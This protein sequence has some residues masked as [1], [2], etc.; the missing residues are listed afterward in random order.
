MLACVIKTLTFFLCLAFPWPAFAQEYSF[1]QYRV[2]HGL[3]SDIIKACA[4]DSLGYFWIATDDGLVKYD[5]IKF[6]TY[7][8]AVHSN[9]TK[10]FF[11]TSK[12][13]LLAFGDLDLIEI[14]NQGDTVVFKSICP[15]YRNPN[16]SSLSYPKLV[17]EDTHGNIWVS[18]SQSVVKLH[19]KSFKR[20]Q[21][22]LTDR[23]PQF[24]RSF[25]IFEDW[26]KNLYIASFQGKVFRFDPTTDRFENY[27]EK[28][29]GQIEYA[30]VIDGKLIVGAADGL[31]ESE[32]LPGGGL[33]K[34][35]LKLKINNVSHVVPMNGHE[36][37][38]AT[39]DTRHYV[40]DFEKNTFQPIPFLINNLNHAFVSQENDLWLSG[41]DGLILMKENLFQKASNDFNN[42]VEAVTED[43]NSRKIFYAANT[44]L[45]EYDILTR[46]SSLALT[47]PNGYFQALLATKEGIWASNAFTVFLFGGGKVIKSF[48]FSKDGRF[49]IDI[50]KDSHGN[51]WLAE[52]GNNSAYV[53]DT[54]YKLHQHK[55][56]LGIEGT[57]NLICEGKNGIYIA[58]TGKNSYL[59]FKSNSDSAFR[60]I[61]VPVR[62]TTHGDFNVT[63]MV[64][65]GD[66]VWLATTEGLLKFDGKKIERENLGAVFT[67]IPV[68]SI[69]THPGNQLL[70]TNAY[71]LVLYN[72][73]TKTYDLFNE[74]CGL[75][76]N[77]ITPRG[78][79][80]S[81]N[82]SVWI[83]TSKGLC[84]STQSLNTLKK[85]PHP[86]FIEMRA[87]GKRVRIGDHKIEYGSFISFQ[88]S[89]ITFPEKEVSIQYRLTPD[90]LWS[91]ITGH[92][93]NFSR[94]PSGKHTLE[95]R[96]K[97]NGP[98]SWSDISSVSFHVAKPFW[99]RAWF[100]FLCVVATGIIV[101]VTV[102]SANARN[103][104]RNQELQK[105]IAD[106]TNA[107]RLT[108]EELEHRNNELDRF[109]YS[110][111][112]DLSAPLKSILG[113]IMVAKM[114][115][116][117][118]VMD[119]YL[120]LIRRS[121]LKLDSFIKDIISY[122]RN[123]RLDVKMETIDFDAMI[124]SI[125]ADLSFTP[126][127]GKINFEIVNLIKSTLK[128]DET[129]LR[130]IFNNLLSNAIKFHHREKKSF[131][132]VIAQESEKEFEFIVEDNG[133]GIS[134]EY[135]EKI[136]DMFFRANETVQGSGL[137]LYILK[138]T[139]SRLKGTV[140]VE[141][142][143]GEGCRFTIHVPK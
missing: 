17:Y 29:A 62:F 7:R 6:T 103:K 44:A 115:Q 15:V 21:F 82:Q 85:T 129:R 53:I 142:T 47:V 133:I 12:G 63:D 118:S 61:S 104:K 126:D 16:D 132:K 14:Q 73:A 96:T 42:F 27:P 112:H 68:K 75:L 23:S 54:D 87:N 137:G 102:W 71:G 134:K 130:I 32:L 111:S 143:L 37:F 30:G 135:K 122:S 116:P 88:V 113:L 38:I 19:D 46:K 98:F 18:E 107:L 119:N 139:V 109:V 5:G 127:A 92:E 94:L 80:I 57:I 101:A 69:K 65:V 141:S 34:S 40:A 41:N 84:F 64:I 90:T 56:P 74:S 39:R 20:Y 131:I 51:I 45:F 140:N 76:S 36:Y 59:F 70:F 28:L 79:F 35:K 123:T 58:S 48:D 31:Y 1:R 105:L 13:K 22:D 106:R 77:T 120:E 108:N 52:P 91:T 3:P 128:S 97:K 86:R 66:L 50:T 2:E 49:I 110:A 9:Y 125:W 33:G 89:S 78:L 138:E 99:Q 67:E 10:G 8:D 11:T 25:T 114:E 81:K 121:I 93:I 26:K 83:G 117:T 95:V 136:F 4:Q 43:V 55:V 100:F 60:N 24:L 124:R 72:P